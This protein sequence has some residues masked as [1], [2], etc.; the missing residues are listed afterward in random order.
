MSSGTSATGRFAA[1]Q[2]LNLGRPPALASQEFDALMAAARVKLAA[3]MNAAGIPYDV[4]QQ[5]TDPGIR[6]TRAAVGR[7]VLRRA[8]IDDAVAQ[9]FLGS[10]TGGML[11]HRAADYGVLRRVVFAADPTATTEPEGRPAPDWTWVPATVATVAFWREPDDSLRIRARLAWEALSVAGPP[12]AY[13]FHALDAHPDVFDAVAYGPE[14]GYV[15]PGCATV[16]V[17]SRSGN[18]VP[19]HETIDAIAARLDAFEVLYGDGTSVL[20]PVRDEQS[21]RPLG[22]RVTVAACQPFFYTTTATLYVRPD[23]DR[24]VLA[25]E[26]LERLTIYQEGLRRIGQRISRNGRIAV[27]S[28]ADPNG[29]PIVEAD[30][31]ESDIVPGYLQLPVPATPSITLVVRG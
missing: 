6:V 8:A 30:V 19:T 2:L 15:E 13:V 25:A 3:E 20:R 16:V 11:D 21:V 27:L 24:A 22:A 4:Q 18:G 7:D 9:M 14:T 28:L 29:Q 12:G 31:E 1:P 5:D 23:G 26:A 10:A 17:Q